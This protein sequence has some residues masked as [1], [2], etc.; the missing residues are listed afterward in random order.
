MIVWGR[1]LG[2]LDDPALRTAFEG[3][4]GNYTDPSTK[5]VARE[6]FWRKHVLLWCARNCL[7]VDGDFAECGVST[8]FG[9]EV[10]A[11]ALDFGKIDRTYWL[12]DTFSGVPAEQADEGSPKPLDDDGGLARRRVKAKFAS[13]PNIK[14][15]PGA[16]PYTLSKNSP[17]KLAF[18]HLDLNNTIAE[19]ETLAV[20]LPRMSAGSYIVLDDFGWARFGRQ[21]AT[22]IVLF[23]QVGLSVLELP[24]GQGL[25]HV[26][27]EVE[28]VS[29]E[30][31]NHIKSLQQGDLRSWPR[32]DDCATSDSSSWE[33]VQMAF[34][35]LQEQ[36]TSAK[37]LLEK[38]STLSEKA[39]LKTHVLALSS[40]DQF[41]V[42][43]K[44]DSAEV[45]FTTTATLSQAHLVRGL[46]QKEIDKMSNL[47]AALK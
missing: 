2:F 14:I 24:T 37:T 36:V 44:G 12:Y 8:G 16:L 7:S 26:T 41:S 45:T 40:A 28:E 4:L 22:E 18:L 11:N 20:L 43:Q 13:F 9:V 46:L 42:V 15:V 5:H 19:L 6:L 32:A 47:L 10:L 25:V 33:D 3:A 23:E 38:K 31:L 1:N 17:T 35:Y 21:H 27:K 29:Q 30:L 34:D 39:A